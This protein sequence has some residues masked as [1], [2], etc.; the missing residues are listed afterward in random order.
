MTYKQATV[1]NLHRDP[2]FAAEYPDVLLEDG[3]HAKLMLALRCMTASPRSRKR[4]RVSRYVISNT[5]TFPNDLSRTY[6][7]CAIATVMIL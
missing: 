6:D 1:E 2:E 5:Y 4:S 7:S 3:E